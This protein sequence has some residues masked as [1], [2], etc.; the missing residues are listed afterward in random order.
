M[1]SSDELA[2]AVVSRITAVTVFWS[3]AL[4]ERTAELAAGTEL[5]RL[6]GLP[7]SLDDA[8][9]R[10]SVPTQGEPPPVTLYDVRLALEVPEPSPELPPPRDEELRAARRELCRLDLAV[11]ARQAMRSRLQALQAPPRPRGADGEPPPPSPAAARLAL[12]DFRGA[13]L[14]RLAGEIAG[15][16]R[17]RETAAERLHELEER[18]RRASSE[19][20]VREHELRKSVL[21]SLRW[22]GDGHGT[23]RLL[24]SYLVPGARWAP[25]YT[26]RFE[27]GLGRAEL[28]LRALVSQATGEDWDGVRL[29]VSTAEPQRWVDLPELPARRIGRRQPPTRRGW[30]PPPADTEELFAD[31]DRSWTRQAED[32][33]AVPSV[34]LE[35]PV[36]AAAAPAAAEPPA[37]AMALLAP[38]GPELDDTGEITLEV[39]NLLEAA[40]APEAASR[41]Q[42]QN[43]LPASPPGRRRSLAVKRLEVRP[44]EGAAAEP[45]LD[46]GNLR[47]RGAEESGRGKLHPLPPGEAYLEIL[48]RLEV[49]V[50]F[51]LSGPVFRARGK[52]ER[53]RLGPLPRLYAEPREWEGF[54]YTY[55]AEEAVGVT[56]DGEFHNVPLLQ[57]PIEADLR[58]VTVPR[59]APEAFRF[60]TFRNPLAAPLPEGPADVYVGRDFLLTTRLGTV[61]PGERSTGELGL[62]VDEAVQVVRNTRFREVSSGLVRGRLGLEHEI[63]I[64]VLN[65]L[66]REVLC[67]VRERVP[68]RREGDETIEVVVGEADPPWERFEPTRHPTAGGYRWRTPLQAGEKR[69]FKASYTIQIPAKHELVGGNRRER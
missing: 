52:A 66:P 48:A 40:A 39:D 9:V 37:A 11:A 23:C 46:Y 6:P 32:D 57:R 68:V 7:L 54:A 38:S 17:E 69:T 14:E 26:V 30:R 20:Q 59:E 60:V 61:A 56:S 51:D 19:R 55:A 27:P 35:A 5:L 49:E 12:L 47:L 4:V 43:L 62:G 65:P 50:R 31:Y 29:S 3:G 28:A 13:E 10:L 24:V 18:H 22:N 8:S 16:R 25:G 1:T 44:R 34:A 2:P 36:P 53:N 63:E 64:E 58:L 33:A 67:E 41:F 15:L 42:D 21:A 45:L